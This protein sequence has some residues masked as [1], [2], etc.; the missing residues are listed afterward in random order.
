MRHRHSGR[1]LGRNSSHRKAL[2]K[3]MMNSLLKHE[4]ITTTVP[5]AKELR[6]YMEPMI[7]LAKQDTV[8]RRRIAFARL[9]DKEMVAK[10]FNEIAPHFKTRPGGYMRILK[11]GY[12]KGD[13]AP[14]AIVELVGREKGTNVA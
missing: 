7:T 4:Q 6:T 9:R 1:Y 10:L 12:R 2:F 11:C 5:K 8:H 13:C 14:I 3:N